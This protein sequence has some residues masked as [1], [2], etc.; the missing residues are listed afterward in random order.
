MN[1]DLV[2]GN[3]KQCRGKLREQWGKLVHSESGVDAGKRDQLSGSMQARHGNSKREAE[4]QLRDF[5]YRNRDWN[6]SG[7]WIRP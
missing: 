7:R 3:W 1:R 4:R 6:L 2:E 5:L